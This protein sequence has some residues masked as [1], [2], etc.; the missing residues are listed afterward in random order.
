MERFCYFSLLKVG[1]GS[2]V[3]KNKRKHLYFFF[4][5]SPQALNC[6]P[7]LRP[8]VATPSLY[9]PLKERETHTHTLT[10][11]VMAIVYTFSIISN[12]CWNWQVVG[13]GRATTSTFG[14]N[15]CF[16]VPCFCWCYKLK[17]SMFVFEKLFRIYS[18]FYFW[19]TYDLFNLMRSF[20]L[21]TISIHLCL[22]EGF[23]FF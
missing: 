12:Q 14:L 15:I 17:L 21:S 22:G 18:W 6:P 5:S 7:T 20:N 1:I 3:L 4:A 2:G 19:I 10:Y 13:V 9:L 11:F 8:L 23:F 16:I